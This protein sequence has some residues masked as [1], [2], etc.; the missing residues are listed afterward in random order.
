ME[1]ATIYMIFADNGLRQLH[2][3]KKNMFFLT[4]AVNHTTVKISR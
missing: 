2:G 3:Q 4:L 1:L